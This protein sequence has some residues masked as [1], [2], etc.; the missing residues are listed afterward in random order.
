VA[1]LTKEQGVQFPRIAEI[2]QELDEI[3]R[4]L[5]ELMARRR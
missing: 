3:K 5:K 2:Q 1:K 4:M